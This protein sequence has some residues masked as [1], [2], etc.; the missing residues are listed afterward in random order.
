MIYLCCFFISH[1]TLIEYLTIGY[2][3]AADRPNLILL[4][5]ISGTGGPRIVH[6]NGYQKE[7]RTF[8]NPGQFR[9]TI[10]ILIK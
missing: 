3:Q 5:R 6:V 4:I 1:K 2:I 7:I 10:T 9:K 8:G